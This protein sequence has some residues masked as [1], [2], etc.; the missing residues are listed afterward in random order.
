M[1]EQ[2]ILK[3][4][5]NALVQRLG[6]SAFALQLDVADARS[7]ATLLERLPAELRAI[8][9]LVNNAGHDV[10]GRR[11]FDLGDLEE[12]ASIIETNV[13]GMV[14]VTHAVAP[15]MVARGRG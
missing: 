11:R 12:W 8:D 6:Q 1:A 15:G 9:I 3:A 5:V 13:T 10:G 14:R 2:G 7:T 4:G